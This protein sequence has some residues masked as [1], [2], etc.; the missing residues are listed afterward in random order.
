MTLA[1]YVTY[2]MSE[3][4][5]ELACS[6]GVPE[7]EIRNWCEGTLTPVFRDESRDVIFDAY[8]ACVRR[9]RES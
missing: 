5:V 7:S 2:A 9:R 8:V 1:S 3:T 4:G 6:R